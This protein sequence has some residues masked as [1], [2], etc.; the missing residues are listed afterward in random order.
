VLLD[1]VKFLLAYGA[2]RIKKSCSDKTAFDLA[3]EN[4]LKD[5]V[6]YLL[7]TVRK[8]NDPKKITSVDLKDTEVLIK[9]ESE[10][11]CQCS[12]F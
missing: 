12:V 10:K 7:R 8:K 5:K 3:E 2:D 9:Q 1:S 6:L 11:E 4:P